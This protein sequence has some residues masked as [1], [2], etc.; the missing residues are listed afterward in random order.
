MNQSTKSGENNS[1]LKIRAHTRK[2]M[3][4]HT[5]FMGRT[6]KAILCV[7]VTSGAAA[8]MIIM[9]MTLNIQYR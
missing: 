2:E 8:P 3:G 6:E 5:F 1:Q 9:I 4:L 7:D